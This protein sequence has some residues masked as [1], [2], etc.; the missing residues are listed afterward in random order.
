MGRKKE[1]QKEK[2]KEKINSW[3][4]FYFSYDFDLSH[5][6]QASAVLSQGA[7]S[8]PLWKRFDERFFWNQYLLKDFKAKAKDYAE[9]RIAFFSSSLF[10]SLHFSSFLFI[11]L[12]F[13]SFLFII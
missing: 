5:S 13:S 2:E 8:S 11:S 10:I 1:K 4:D 7:L 12:H 6:M 9:V 3:V